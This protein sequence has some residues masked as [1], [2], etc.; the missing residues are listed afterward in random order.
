MMRVDLV[1]AKIPNKTAEGRYHD[2][3]A[4]RHTHGTALGGAGVPLR[5][6]MR[7]M[8]HSDLRLTMRYCHAE[9]VDQAR[10]LGKLPSLPAPATGE[11][12]QVRGI[13]A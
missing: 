8:R 10:S 1:A 3:H 12:G 13:T 2:F 7:L 9:L 5:D 4:L 6:H 11:A